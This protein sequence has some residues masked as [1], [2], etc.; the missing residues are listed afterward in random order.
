MN[1]SGIPIFVM[2]DRIV[3]IFTKQI[4]DYVKQGVTYNNV[5]LILY[6]VLSHVQARK[7]Q[8]YAN[9][10][11]KLLNSQKENKENADE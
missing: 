3:E 6:K 9:E 10:Y 11:M 1:E 7:A 5:E 4:D 2:E 8:G